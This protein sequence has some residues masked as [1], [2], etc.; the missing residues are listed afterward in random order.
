MKC[1]AIG[2]VRNRIGGS[3]DRDAGFAERGCKMN[4][5]AVHADHRLRAAGC[6]DQSFDAGKV[7]L[8][9]FDSTQTFSGVRR[10]V[11]YQRET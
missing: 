1:S 7:N 9:S 3:I 6:I 4:R 11:H 5:T 10:T 2:P 8:C